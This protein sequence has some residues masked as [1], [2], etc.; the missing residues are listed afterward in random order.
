M[1][2][3]QQKQKEQPIIKHGRPYK[4]ESF[5]KLYFLIKYVGVQLH[6]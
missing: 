5:Y 6:A 4:I 2:T 1:I 3:K